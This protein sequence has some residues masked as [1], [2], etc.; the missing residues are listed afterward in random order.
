MCQT[1]GGSE[2]NNEAGAYCRRAA[3]YLQG[4][5]SAGQWWRGL[6]N[7]AQACRE[8]PSPMASGRVVFAA[9]SKLVTPFL[10]PTGAHCLA[11]ATKSGPD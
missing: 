11:P 3:V 2:A 4:H 9:G 10:V 5:H 8:R 1:G 7:L 6:V